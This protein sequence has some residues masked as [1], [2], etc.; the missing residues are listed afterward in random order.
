MQNSGLGLF[1]EFYWVKIKKKA[2]WVKC[3]EQ[4]SSPCLH[5]LK[6]CYLVSKPMP[7][8]QIMTSVL[9]AKF[10]EQTLDCAVL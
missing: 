8:P 5:L 3:H 10:V 7:V 9:E 1:S 2:Y 6:S 4:L